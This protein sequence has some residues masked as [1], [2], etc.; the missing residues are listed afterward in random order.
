MAKESNSLAR[1]RSHFQPLSRA[2]VR[3]VDCH[4]A[5][6]SF[7][8]LLPIYYLL[9]DELWTRSQK[10][11]NP[12]DPGVFSPV[13]LLPPTGLAKLPAMGGWRCKMTQN[14]DEGKEERENFLISLKIPSPSSTSAMTDNCAGKSHTRRANSLILLLALPNLEVW[15]WFLPVRNGSP[16]V[17]H[18]SLP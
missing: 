6:R 17:M 12:P 4:S 3:Y 2:D 11:N 13:H 14:K 10:R 1:N 9:K 18:S 8:L 7:D 16:R 15:L 5:G